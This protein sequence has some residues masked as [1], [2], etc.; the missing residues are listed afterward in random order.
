MMDFSQG[1]GQSSGNGGDIIPNGQ[2]AWA[3]MTVRAIKASQTGGEYIDVELTLDDGQPFARRKV[4]E[5]IGN[6]F[7]A[8]NTEAYRQMGMIAITRILES[9]KGAGPNNPAGYKLTEFEQLS[10]LRVPIKIK[11]EKGTG[12]YDDKN[13]VAEWLTPNPQSQSGF[14]DYELLVKGI[15]N[16]APAS[17]PQTAPANGFGGASATSSGGFGGNQQSNGGSIANAASQ[18]GGQSGFGQPQQSGASA[19]VAQQ[20]AQTGFA[21]TATSPSDAPAGWLQQ[22]NGG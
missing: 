10:G 22:A 16:K 8:G 7:N 12:G 13:K 9:A 2:L 1:A 20:Q 19:T 15:Y 17:A 14:K 4:W 11:I 5:M 6:P 18:G 3:I 21:A